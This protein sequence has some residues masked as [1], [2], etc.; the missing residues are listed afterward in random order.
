MR[1]RDLEGDCFVSRPWYS[2]KSKSL[3]IFVSSSGKYYYF[4]HGSISGELRRNSSA[5]TY[6]DFY[7]SDKFGNKEIDMEKEE[8]FGEMKFVVLTTKS[9]QLNGFT[10]EQE[11]FDFMENV[12]AR[13]S[14]V[15]FTMFKA[16]QKFM[17]KPIILSENIIK[18][19]D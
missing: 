15:Q 8:L 13:N 4:E 10:T 16:Y 2:Q 18:L 9:G 5:Y 14:R 12:L 17:P 7:F 6:D 19:E 11:A 3:A 1:L